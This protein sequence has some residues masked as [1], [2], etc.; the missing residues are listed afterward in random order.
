MAHARLQ[1]DANESVDKAWAARVITADRIA[2][3]E[4]QTEAAARSSTAYSK[5]YDLGQRS[6]IDL[7]NAEN[8]SFNAQVSLIS[9]RSVAVFADYQLLAAMGK[10]LDYIRAPHP[11]DAEP[12]G[13]PGTYGLIPVKI[14]ADPDQHSAARPGAAQCRW[15][16]HPAGD[17]RLCAADARP[18]DPVAV[19]GAGAR[20]SADEPAP[21]VG[22]SDRWLDPTVDGEAPVLQLVPLDT[23][24]ATSQGGSRFRA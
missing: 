19:P 24:G 4:L 9:A 8:T 12:L 6:L 18:P 13:P 15:A 3:L 11:V 7:L 21:K 20:A 10:L 2:T 1:R 16:A 17:L 23:A 14:A 5:E 22:F